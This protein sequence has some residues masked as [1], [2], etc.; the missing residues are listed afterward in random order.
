V[1]HWRS[2]LTR[3][4]SISN[5][6][7]AAWKRNQRQIPN[8]SLHGGPVAFKTHVNGWPQAKQV[9]GTAISEYAYRRVGFSG[10]SKIRWDLASGAFLLDT[11]TAGGI[12][13]HGSSDSVD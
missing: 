5:G 1:R 7:E 11:R 12:L 13:V 3:V 10:E 6:V 9:P 2:I 8:L 4:V